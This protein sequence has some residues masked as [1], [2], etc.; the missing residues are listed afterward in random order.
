MLNDDY[1]PMDGGARLE[2]FLMNTEKATRS[3]RTFINGEF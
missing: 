1:T 3:C 2:R